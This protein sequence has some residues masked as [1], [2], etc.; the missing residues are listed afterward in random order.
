M[1]RD[2]IK[3]DLNESVKKRETTKVSVL[4]MLLSEVYDKEKKKRYQ[5]KME[6][7]AT[8]SDKDLIDVIA[9]EIKKRRES[10]FIFE[11][12]GS[13]NRADKEKEELDILLSYM[14]EQL[15]EDE[16]SLIIDQAIRDSKA[17]GLK[18]IGAVMALV[19]PQVKG[20]ADGSEV[21]RLVKGALS[22]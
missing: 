10:I 11:K 17:T 12:A 20:K 19:M 8:L 13:L 9:S 1:I 2:R 15:S 7:D 6:E 3:S 18:D 5:D 4:R 22:R 14:P 21:G 16:I